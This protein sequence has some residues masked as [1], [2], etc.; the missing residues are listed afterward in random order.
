M[1]SFKFILVSVVIL[2]YSSGC[3]SSSCACGY[4]TT[5]GDVWRNS[6]TLDF[7]Q[8]DAL[9]L[10]KS[11]FSI[12]T[13]STTPSGTIKGMTNLAANI[14]DYNSGL[15]MKVSAYSGSGQVYVA[16]MDSTIQ[17]LY[18]SFRVTSVIPSVP[19]VCYSMFLYRNDTCEV[20]IEFLSSDP[21]YYNTVH[22]SNQ[23]TNGGT[24]PK[25]Y[26]V[27]TYS[28]QDYTATHTH[29]LDW[30]PTATEFYV[31]NDLRKTLTD[32]VPHSPMTWIFNIWSNG[33]P[34]WTHGPPTKDAVVTIFQVDAYYNSTSLSQFQ[35][36]CIEAGSPAPCVV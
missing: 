24:D 32:N 4:K 12:Q 3:L 20:D 17:F 28:G 11:K 6:I 29:R 21:T 31:N 13:W 9:T 35:A 19:G 18:G 15:G 2:A 8:S 26:Q 25:S 16:E 27:D 30:L 34:G 14:Y 7:T 5:S 10:A 33:D 1:S 23:P 22:Y 36:A